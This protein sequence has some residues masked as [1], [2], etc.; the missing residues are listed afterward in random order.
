MTFQNE[1][2]E[3]MSIK[4]K[5]QNILKYG[6][7]YNDYIIYTDKIKNEIGFIEFL[8]KI[9]KLNDDD[10]IFI[11]TSLIVNANIIKYRDVD[12]SKGNIKKISERCHIII[13]SFD[14]DYNK[15]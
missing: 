5:E 8:E 12:L 10:F 6:K 11:L 3:K 4:L 9:D 15:Y 2:I 7:K 14:R 13:N 1:I